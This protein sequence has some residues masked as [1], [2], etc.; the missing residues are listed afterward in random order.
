MRHIACSASRAG[1]E[2]IAADCYCDLDL[3]ECAK[4]A[5]QL[6]CGEG[7]DLPR[8][9]ESIREYAEDNSVDA[10]LLGPGLEE[11]RLGGI[12]VLNNS[13]EK[14]SKVSDK[15]WLA[16][17]LDRKGYPSIPTEKL[18]DA[19]AL[20]APLRIVK[21][22]KGAGGVGTFLLTG[23]CE[24]GDLQ[25]DLIIQEWVSGIPASISLIGNSDCAAAIALNEQ[26]MGIPWLGSR[27]FRYCGNITPLSLTKVDRSSEILSKDILRLGEEI[28]SDLGLVGSNGIDFIL[29][30]EG[31]VVVE[32]N[33]RF[34]G[35]LDSVELSTG[36]NI[37]QA[38]LDSFYGRLPERPAPKKVAGRAILFAEEQIKITDDFRSITSWVAD[39]PPPGS[40]IRKDSPVTSILATGK[41]RTE[42]LELIRRRSSMLRRSCY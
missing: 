37:F 29:T 2:V 26:M 7:G 36:K 11:M 3:A 39:V 6:S 40:I 1:H 35:S 34:Q 9:P 33:P 18:E 15:L 23:D 28:V 30:R 13:P 24:L 42:V 5:I 12:W 20:K 16:G 4:C 41:E 10:V 25:G 19:E 27:G 32:V 8:S 17:W 21:P 38:H 31:P 14:I 22:R